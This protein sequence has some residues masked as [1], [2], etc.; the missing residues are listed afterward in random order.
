M[1]HIPQK[2]ELSSEE[3]ATAGRVWGMWFCVS[4]SYVVG[5]TV[6]HITSAFGIC[7]S[8]LKDSLVCALGQLWR[9]V[10]FQMLFA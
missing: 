1:I 5:A 7:F 3:G 10:R 9:K 6:K 8:H 2:S 4:Q